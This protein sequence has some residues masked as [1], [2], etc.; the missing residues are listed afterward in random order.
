MHAPC[1]SKPNLTITYRRRRPVLHSSVLSMTMPVVPHPTEQ[2]QTIL[3]Q[4]ARIPQTFPKAL[5]S[6]RDTD[7]GPTAG[8]DAVGRRR[9][10]G[11]KPLIPPPGRFSDLRHRIF[12]SCSL[13]FA[14]RLM[15]CYGA[16][17]WLVGWLDGWCCCWCYCYLLPS[18]PRT[19]VLLLSFCGRISSLPPP[20]PSTHLE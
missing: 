13:L 14:C 1:Q 10:S 15:P 16:A 3:A 19:V 9:R 2:R 20:T 17:G 18:S 5:T 11:A 12:H 6:P 4:S 8:V 7:K